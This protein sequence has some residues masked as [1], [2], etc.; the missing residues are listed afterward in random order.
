MTGLPTDNHAEDELAEYFSKRCGILKVDF[1]T[2]KPK[3]KLY[4]T[5]EGYLKGDAWL[6]FLRPESVELALQLTDGAEYR[7]GHRITVRPAEF[8]HK[9]ELQKRRKVD[10][11]KVKARMHQL[12]KCVW[13]R[14]RLRLVHAPASR[15]PCVTN[16]RG[17]GWVGEAGRYCAPPRGG[18]LRKLEWY[19]DGATSAKYEKIV[20][21]K[22]VFT[23]AEMDQDA[24]LLLDL[25]DDL[26]S[27]CEKL[28]DVVNVNVFDK[29][30][31]GVCSVKFRESDAAIACVQLMNGRFFGGRK[32]EVALYDGKSRYDIVGATDDLDEE[33]RLKRYGDWLE[34]RD[35]S[36]AAAAAAKAFVKPPQAPAA[37]TGAKRKARST[38]DADDDGE[39][40]LDDD[41]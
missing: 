16:V 34:G 20:I 2:G 36:A 3:V 39:A 19:D 8:E 12:N 5:A 11:R 41:A 24:G 10:K 23:Q 22:H 33:T 18:G 13:R 38:A 25:K 29:H 4:R 14:R 35:T 26:R 6:S 30:P 21:F 32:L 1:E 40:D 9:G 17:R 15:R 31:E 27:E 37:P 28:G 7:P